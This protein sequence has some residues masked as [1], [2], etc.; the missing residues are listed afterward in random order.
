MKTLH[1]EQGD[2]FFEIGK[3]RKLIRLAQNISE[4]FTIP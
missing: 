2:G 1:K 3:C 4:F